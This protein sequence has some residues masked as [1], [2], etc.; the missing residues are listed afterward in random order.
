VWEQADGG[1]TEEREEEY[2]ALATLWT[3][4]SLWFLNAL[5]HACW[6]QRP[7]QEPNSSSG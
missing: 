2:K 3:D 5:L 7:R 6:G 1:L 4:P